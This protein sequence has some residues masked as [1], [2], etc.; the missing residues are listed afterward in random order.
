MKPS[1]GLEL[2]FLT[3]TVDTLPY[4]SPWLDVGTA[5]E[6]LTRIGITRGGKKRDRFKSESEGKVVIR[7]GFVLHAVD[8]HEFTDIIGQAAATLPLS[9]AQRHRLATKLME[10]ADSWGQPW[11]KRDGGSDG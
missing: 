8:P 2:Q 9:L 6:V 5:T 3:Y 11:H 1:D 4:G 10:V 7:L